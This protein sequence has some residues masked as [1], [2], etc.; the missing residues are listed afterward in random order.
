[1]KPKAHASLIELG[2]RHVGLAAT[3]KLPNYGAVAAANFAVLQRA[4]D[5]E[6][7][8]G[9]DVLERVLNGLRGAYFRD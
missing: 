1:M 3:T 7:S 9:G 8:T 5:I 6:Y 4:Q 2:I